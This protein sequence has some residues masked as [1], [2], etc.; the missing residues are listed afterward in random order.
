MLSQ[1]GELY[2]VPRQLAVGWIANR[3]ILPLLD[4][5]DEISDVKIRGQCVRQI[6]QYQRSSFLPVVV[7]CRNA[8]YEM[9]PYRLRL[10]TAIEARPLDPKE[11]M[12]VLRRAG[13]NLAGLRAAVRDDPQMMDL[14]TSPLLLNMLNSTYHGLTTAEVRSVGN[15][16][17]R[18]DQLVKAYVEQQLDLDGSPS[19]SG[20]GYKADATRA[21]LTALALALNQ[22]KISILRPE[23]LD[24][25][26]L[27]SPW[28][29][30][31]V[32]TAPKLLFGIIFGLL[33]GLGEQD[34]GLD[35]WLLGGVGGAAL[36]ASIR[37]RT[38]AL[39]GAVAGI[40]AGVGFTA[41]A[42]TR[43]GVIRGAT[44]GLI[45]GLIF[46]LLAAFVGDRPPPAELLS[47]SWRR[48]RT[49]V[50]RAIAVGLLAALIYATVIN[51]IGATLGH[52]PEWITGR[53]G[54]LAIATIGLLAGLVVALIGGL[55]QSTM[56]VS[57]KPND[58]IRRSARNGAL[59]G[60][61]ALIAVGSA[62]I[63]TFQLI[64]GTGA[65]QFGFV[66]G[67]TFG[68]LVSLAAG[69]GAVLQHYLLRMFL[70]RYKQAPLHWIRWLDWV[71][72]RRLLYWAA[73][74]GY[75]FIHPLVQHH[76]AASGARNESV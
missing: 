23:R 49:R 13:Q 22:H 39:T 17:R 70:W 11:V 60:L 6:N 16:A 56:P 42:S 64:G 10:R 15:L 4:G 57:L 28:A 33:F 37:L 61:V 5:L 34:I 18:R 66:C 45:V 41:V 36:A 62:S 43:V 24:I 53:T 38:T 75:V 46:G 29:R 27:E 73:G 54:L 35:F 3:S 59:A 72:H 63:P 1:L 69:W 52:P 55:T 31:L 30:R 76:F 26:W 2:S 40:T 9:L 58:G 21:W 32:L 19:T 50:S 14:M 20:A 51:I 25:D 7:C 12:A 68:I 44:A 71:T 8:E 65:G 67:T 47:W 74:G 48:T